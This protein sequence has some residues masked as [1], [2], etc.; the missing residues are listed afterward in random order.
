MAMFHIEEDSRVIYTNH[1]FVN[2]PTL[3][4]AIDE[5]ATGKYEPHWTSDYDDPDYGSYE[6]STEV[7]ADTIGPH[8]P[9]NVTA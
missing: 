7:E 3:Q 8:K 5:V 9:I 1:F 4:A 6:D 2:A